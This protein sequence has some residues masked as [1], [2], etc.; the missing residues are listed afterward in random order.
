MIGGTLKGSVNMRRMDRKSKKRITLFE[1][2]LRKKIGEIRAL[3]LK[4]E[5][6][7]LRETC[8]E[9]YNKA[10]SI[11]ML[12][13]ENPELIAEMEEQTGKYLEA[14]REL[15]SKYMLLIRSASTSGESKELLEKIEKTLPDISTVFSKFEKKYNTSN[16][17]D[18]DIQL[19]I[20]KTELELDGLPGEE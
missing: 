17:I 2:T 10:L 12:A 14:L 7:Q 4:I 6:T 1:R 8:E 19:S 13:R 18:T 9:I 11:S 15:L 5:K 20:L 3:S 16:I